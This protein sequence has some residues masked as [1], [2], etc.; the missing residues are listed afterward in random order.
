MVCGIAAELDLPDLENG[1]GSNVD[2]NGDRPGPVECRIGRQVVDILA[3]DGDRH[4][5]AITGLFIQSG[6][7]PLTVVARL[8]DHAEIAGHRLL[9]VADETG[10]VFQRFFQVGIGG[11]G[12]EVDLVA[13]RIGH[14]FAFVFFLT[15]NGDA[16]K[17]EGVSV[18][19]QDR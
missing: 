6:D 15:E 3:V 19:D 13:H 4:Q 11:I 10:T 8:D 14:L 12:F 9:L 17:L 16:E 2:G 5:A 7:Q 18:A 1:A